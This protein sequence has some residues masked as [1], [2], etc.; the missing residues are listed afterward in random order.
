MEGNSD[1]GWYTQISGRCTNFT[2]N[3]NGYLHIAFTG[4]YAFT[5]SLQQHNPTCNESL[6]PYPYTWDSVEASRYSNTAKTDIYVPISHFSINLKLCIGLAFKGWYTTAATMFSKVELVKTVPNGFLVPS[7]LDSAPLRFACTRPNSFAFAID[8]G[9]PKYAQ[10]VISYLKAA[11]IH[12]TFFTV[13]AAL[14]DATTNLTNVYAEMLAQGHQIAYH[15]FTH[16]P[17]EGLPSL[18]AIDWELTNDMAA[19]KSQLGIES[20][21]F[22]PPFGTEGARIRQRLAA[23]IPGA[24]FIEWSVDVQDYLWALST[25][26]E[27]QVQSFQSDVDKGG[28]LV[29]CHY[30]YKTT[31]EYIPTFIEIAKRTGKQLMRVD[32]C[33]EDPDAPPL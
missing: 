18:A 10:Q 15:S 7:K 6:N 19:V 24:Q 23:L 21:Y 33:M 5:I 4:S 8:D 14:L 22:R 16:P 32:Q 3:T 29:V 13:G 9:D 30:L 28:N 20:T 26:P 17:M 31:V 12:V 11:N 27:K 2:P 1:L 25:T